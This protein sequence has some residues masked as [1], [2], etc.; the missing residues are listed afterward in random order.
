MLPSKFKVREISR[1]Q[2]ISVGTKP[3]K[4]ILIHSLAEKGSVA[5][6]YAPCFPYKQ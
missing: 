1:N 3:D 6:P 5:T 2:R 4:N